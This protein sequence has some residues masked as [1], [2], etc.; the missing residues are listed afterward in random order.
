[1]FGG[2]SEIKRGRGREREGEGRRERDLHRERFERL[3]KSD[4][5]VPLI[6]SL[7]LFAP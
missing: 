5:K 2:E 1:V 3:E 6:H 4:G 7:S